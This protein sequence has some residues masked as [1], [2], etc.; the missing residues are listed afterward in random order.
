LRVEA[1]SLAS[2]RARASHLL[3]EGAAEQA[4]TEAHGANERERARHAAARAVRAAEIEVERAE[5]ER[6]GV[7]EAIRSSRGY[8]APDAATSPPLRP[9]QQT[10]EAVTMKHN[11]FRTS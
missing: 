5:A 1:R 7:L 8:Q 9:I 4:R 11:S 2:E 6:R 10:K 3:A